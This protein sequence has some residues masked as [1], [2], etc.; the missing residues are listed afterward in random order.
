MRPGAGP[1]GRRCSASPRRRSAAAR[2]EPCGSGRTRCAR[3]WPAPRPCRSDGSR[4]RGRPAC[5]RPP[6]AGGGSR[7]GCCGRPSSGG[8]APATSPASSSSP[9]R[10]RRPTSRD[11]PVWSACTYG[12]PW[13]SIVLAY[14]RPARS[15][16]RSSEDVDALTL[17]QADDRSLGVGSLAGPEA[18]A[19]RLA[20]AVDRVDAG[21]LDVE[22]LLDRDLDLGLVGA[23][24]HQEGVLVRVEEPVALLADHR[25]DQHVAVV[26]VEVAHWAA[27]SLVSVSVWLAGWLSVWP[28]VSVA[29]WL[30][31]PSAPRAPTNV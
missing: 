24:T 26:L 6:C 1:A 10:S 19:T 3:P 27:S 28:A 20:R 25:C 14:C 22:D 5:D 30:A 9:R 18:G 4:R 31:V 13:L 23:R 29:G 2:S 15:G 16:D 12:C 7:P 11:G 21:H 8:G 17:R